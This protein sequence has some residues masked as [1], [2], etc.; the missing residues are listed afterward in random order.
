[1]HCVTDALLC[2]GC[3]VVLQMPCC[4]TDALLCYRCLV[5]LQMPCWYYE[6][7]D[8]HSTVSRRDGIDEETE[9]RYRREGAR[10]IMDTGTKMGLYPSTFMS[11]QP[12]THTRTHA[13]T[14]TRTHAR[15]HTHTHTLAAL[16]TLTV[17][18]YMCPSQIVYR[19]IIMCKN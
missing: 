6:K 10:F 5:V 19:C 11:L 8:L 15:T 3:L 12:Y 16:G 7:K 1:M 18:I 2:Y 4:V 13:R 17:N 9:A 14:H